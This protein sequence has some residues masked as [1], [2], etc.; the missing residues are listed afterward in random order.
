[1]ADPRDDRSPDALRVLYLERLI[2]ASEERYGRERTEELRA[3][4]AEVADHMV[5]VALFPL[6]NEDRPGF[7]LR[8]TDAGQ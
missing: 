5:K 3:T 4:F 8:A 6:E 1:M 7:L 2:R